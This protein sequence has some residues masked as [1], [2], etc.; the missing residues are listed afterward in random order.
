MVKST[1]R[2]GQRTHRD[3]W[4]TEPGIAEERQLQNIKWA[5]IASTDGFAM[6]V[7]VR[8]E[9]EAVAKKA[10]EELLTTCAMLRVEIHNASAP[11]RTSINSTGEWTLSEFPVRIIPFLF[12]LTAPV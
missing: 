6:V 11:V 3:T 12:L 8:F 7:D 2:S 10:A 5:N 4:K 9:D 1:G